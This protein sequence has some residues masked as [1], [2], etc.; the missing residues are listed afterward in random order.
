[1]LLILAVGFLAIYFKIEETSNRFDGSIAYLSGSIEAAKRAQKP[2]KEEPTT[3]KPAQ[4][5]AVSFGTPFILAAGGVMNLIDGND[6]LGSV[7][8][9][10]I[11]DSRCKPGVQCIWAGELNAELTL[12]NITG[13]KRTLHLGLTT[14]SCEEGLTLTGITETEATLVFELACKGEEIGIKP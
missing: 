10:K 6:I 12:T 14:K 8:L 2:P 7:T 1:M 5:K 13:D 9:E 4:S 11:N 3:E